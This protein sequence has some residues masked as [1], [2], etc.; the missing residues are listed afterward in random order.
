MGALGACTFVLNPSEAQCETDADCEARG[1]DGSSCVDQLC[2]DGAGGGGGADPIWGCLGN[3]VEPEPDTSQTLEFTFRLAFAVDGAPLTTGTVDVC[4][5]LDVD[6]TG[7]SPDFPKGLT[8]DANGDVTVT[9]REGFDGFVRVEDMDIVPSRI[10]VGRPVVEP[11]KVKEVQLL[12][13]NEYAALAGIAQ[14]EVDDTRGTAILY[15]V[16]CSGEAAGSVSFEVPHA[17]GES[18]E[19]YLINQAPTIPPNAEST[20]ADGFGGFFNL[21]PALAVARAIRAEDQAFVGESSF[22]VLAG[23]ISYV[24]IAPTPQ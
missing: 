6:C 14:G 1:F 20:D 16:D 23:T 2:T 22:Q 8:P 5:K 21:P 10:Y 18:I 19:F 13:P 11:P 9:V 24:Q 12:R 17:D 15:G 4:D 3:V 7:T